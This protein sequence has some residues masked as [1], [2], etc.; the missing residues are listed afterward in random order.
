MDSKLGKDEK[1]SFLFFKFVLDVLPVLLR[2]GVSWM[3]LVPGLGQ[4]GYSTKD[5]PSH[6]SETAAGAGVMTEAEESQPKRIS[7]ALSPWLDLEQLSLVL[8]P[9]LECNGVIS[10]HCNLSLP[11]SRNSPASASQRQGFAMLTRLVLNSW[12]HDSPTLDFQSAGITGVSHY[13]QPVFIHTNITPLGSPAVLNPTPILPLHYIFK[14]IFST[15]LLTH[16][17]KMGFHHV[18]QAG[19]ELLGSSDLPASTSQ[20]AGIIDVSHHARPGMSVIKLYKY[21]QTGPIEAMESLTLLPRLQC[22]GMILAHCNLHL[23]VQAILPASRVTEITGAC[24]HTQ[25]IFVFLVMMGFH[26]V[27]Q[28]GLKL[29]TSSDLPA[30]PSKSAAITGMSHQG[31]LI[32]YIFKCQCMYI[33]VHIYFKKIFF[34]TESVCPS[35]WSAV[36]C[37]FTML[38]RLVSNFWSQVILLPWLPKMGFHHVGQ[39]GLELPT[40]GD[41]PAL[42]AKMLGLQA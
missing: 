42:A 13:A 5:S 15:K 32:M 19:L 39:A 6:C 2:S 14:A 23:W 33:Y 11:S 12:P 1:M 28:A 3:A 34:E 30:L 22:S 38:P 36:R 21:C 25:L 8:S 10:A 7:V 17:A 35:R 31:W 26:H 27:C 18:G 24:H 4:N 40:S 37:G 16:R 41:S 29:L 9:R 20:S